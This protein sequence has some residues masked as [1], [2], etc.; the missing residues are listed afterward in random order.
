ME[1]QRSNNV[2]NISSIDL[3]KYEEK[4]KDSRNLTDKDELIIYKKDIKSEDLSTTY[5]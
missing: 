2:P 4:I 3:G 5:V 1:E